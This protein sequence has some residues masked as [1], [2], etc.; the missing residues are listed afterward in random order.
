MKYQSL[1][2]K[3][4]D[5]YSWPT[6]YMFKFIVPKGKEGEIFE[7]FPTHEVSTKE[8]RQGNYISVTAKAMMASS[9]AVIEIYQKA[10]KVSGVV[11]L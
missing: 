1:K 11:S 6:L 10:E 9:D 3:L 2:D 5:Q 7:I 8:S 4:D